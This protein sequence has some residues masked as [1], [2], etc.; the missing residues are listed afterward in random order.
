MDPGDFLEPV[1]DDLK[2]GLCSLVLDDPHVC[3]EGHAFCR[4]CIFEYV[5][6][7]QSCPVDHHS[8]STS[9]I[10]AVLPLQHMI[11]KLKVRCRHHVQ[12]TG[13]GQKPRK[14]RRKNNCTWVGTVEDL[15]EHLDEFCGFVT[16]PCKN[17]GCNT[18]V[19]RRKMVYHR[20][21][22]K[23]RM[24]PCPDCGKDHPFV[25][26]DDHLETCPKSLIPCPQ[27]CE[28]EIRREHKESHELHSCEMTL[29][30]CHCGV[31]HH[32]KHSD[33]HHREHL[34]RHYDL[35][36]E[37]LKAVEQELADAKREVETLRAELKKVRGHSDT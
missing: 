34:P 4:A 15:K 29:L 36:C 35:M 31:E 22:C 37:R 27:G 2:C 32:R 19:E 11:S 33:R 3:H 9:D 21:A 18:L 25:D 16:T 28:R 10:A 30:T 23:H 12:R 7:E 17:A 13:D 24:M 26:L 20:N 6:R 1:G 14:R 8:L 5:E